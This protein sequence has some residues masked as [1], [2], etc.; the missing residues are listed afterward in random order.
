MKKHIKEWGYD[1]F[2]FALIIGMVAG[3]WIWKNIDR[4]KELRQWIQS[5]DEDKM[6]AV[7]ERDKY[8]LS[9]SEKKELIGYLQSISKKDI[10]LLKSTDARTGGTDYGIDIIIDNKTYRLGH[11][12]IVNGD[13]LIEYKGEDYWII[14]NGL[15]KFLEQMY[16]K[17]EY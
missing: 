8:T 17:A 2:F 6:T 4:T 16:H 15:K 13:A 14:C 3:F 7:V 1:I 11:S 12:F 10:E 9:L 5:L